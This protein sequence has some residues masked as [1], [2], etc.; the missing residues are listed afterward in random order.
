MSGLGFETWLYVY[1]PTNYL[2]DHGDFEDSRFDLVA[3]KSSESNAWADFRRCIKT[4]IPLVLEIMAIGG[5]KWPATKN[6]KG[7]ICRVT[8]LGLEQQ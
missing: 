3:L 1:K 2:L 8:A 7:K 5:E 4:C 6:G